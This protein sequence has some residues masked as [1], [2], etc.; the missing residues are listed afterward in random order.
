MR[1]QARSNVVFVHDSPVSSV[2]N[3]LTHS[4]AAATDI[5]LAF[6]LAFAR[7][8]AMSAGARMVWL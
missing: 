3:W 1:P 6:G 8:D 2:T 7:T 5:A 4:L